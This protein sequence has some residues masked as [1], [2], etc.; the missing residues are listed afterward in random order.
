[1]WKW[2]IRRETA[3]LPRMPAAHRPSL[4]KPLAKAWFP[5][6]CALS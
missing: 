2:G 1:M 4:G 3:I 6:R 5:P